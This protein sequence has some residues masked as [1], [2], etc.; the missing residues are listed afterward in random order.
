MKPLWLETGAVDANEEGL[1]SAFRTF[2]LK[3]L[4]ENL[5]SRQPY[6]FYNTWNFQER[7]KWWNGKKYLD[8]MNEERMLS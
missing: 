6:I 4:T 1:A 8:S 5:A 7:N 2:V 3:H